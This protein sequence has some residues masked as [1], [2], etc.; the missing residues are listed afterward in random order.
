LGFE[1]LNPVPPV[2]VEMHEPVAALVAEQ[3]FVIVLGA[4]VVPLHAATSQKYTCAEVK[5]TY[6]IVVPP[7]LTEQTILSA[8]VVFPEGV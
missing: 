7:W 3:L 8:H 4:H 5:V 6:P 1:A 2:T